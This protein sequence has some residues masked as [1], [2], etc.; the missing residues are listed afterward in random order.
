MKKLQTKWGLSQPS[1]SNGCAYA[2]LDNDGDLDLIVNNIDHSPFLYR[3]DVATKDSNFLK[4][5]LK[6]PDS[7]IDGIGSKIQLWHGNNTQFIEHYKSRGFQ[8]S[9]SKYFAFW[10]R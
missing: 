3:N 8:S 10:F 1:F 6:G 7:N 5:K 4:I 9:V 2:D